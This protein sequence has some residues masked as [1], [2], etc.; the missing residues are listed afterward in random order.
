M[1]VDA[2]R[3]RQGK[4][5]LNIGSST[6]CLEDFVNLD[7]SI[8]L[9]LVP[10][11]P[12]LRWV[13]P[14]EKKSVIERYREARMRTK[15]LRH[16]CRKP[17]PF[18]DGSVDHILCS[19]FLEHISPKEALGVLQEFRRVLKVEIG[20]IHLILPDL[21]LQVEQY[22]KVKG[23]PSAADNLVRGMLFRREDREGR[24]FRF[25]EF[26]G[27]FGLVHYWMYDQASIRAR[28]DACGFE[29][30]ETTTGFPSKEY[31]KDDGISLHVVGRKSRS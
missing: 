12:V 19:H 13:L 31:R 25:L 6:Q 5:W 8:F 21:G 11:Y 14:A 17:L 1:N 23:H 3:N 7:N 16:D 29:I 10:Y 9:W 18:P 26:L 27:G 4:L 30:L 2:Y 20:M 28:V 24:L 22:L 15:V